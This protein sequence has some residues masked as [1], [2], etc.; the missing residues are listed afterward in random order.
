MSIA[1]HHVLCLLRAQLL[2]TTNLTAA[3]LWPSGLHY[4]L[5][6]HDEIMV[7]IQKCSAVEA[8]ATAVMDSRSL[9]G[10]MGIEVPSTVGAASS[11]LDGLSGEI[12]SNVL[13]MPFGC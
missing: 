10:G 13:Q 6:M 5:T 4:S 8:Q 7:D 12:G 1:L 3:V 2:N 11:P 9:P